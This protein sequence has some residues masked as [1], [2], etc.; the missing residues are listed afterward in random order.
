MNNFREKLI[1]FFSYLR[2]YKFINIFILTL[3]SI[4]FL[5]FIFPIDFLEYVLLILI[6]F[7]PIFIVHMIEP[8][9]YIPSIDYGNSSSWIK[10]TMLFIKTMCKHYITKYLKSYLLFLIVFLVAILFI[11]SSSLI[12]IAILTNSMQQSLGLSLILLFSSFLLLEGF[13]LAITIIPFG[14]TM[15]VEQLNPITAIFRCKK[16]L[17][18]QFLKQVLMILAVAIFFVPI[19]FL[20][21]YLNKFIYI[22][23]ILRLTYFLIIVN[24]VI[25]DTKERMF[26]YCTNNISKTVPD[27]KYTFKKQE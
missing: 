22:A 25:F 4:G 10:K 2:D 5:W 27:T 16:I 21:D 11:Y 19:A 17:K 3:Y 18:K 1:R 15:I 8:K 9:D 24:F 26:I 13:A 6:F 14:T 20:S 12:S 23:I 7:V